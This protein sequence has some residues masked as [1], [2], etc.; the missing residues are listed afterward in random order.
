MLINS[1]L[2][3]LDEAHLKPT[4]VEIQL[5]YLEIAIP[6][7][8]KKVTKACRDMFNREFG[9]EQKY[10]RKFKKLSNPEEDKILFRL[11]FGALSILVIDW[12]IEDRIGS[13]RLDRCDPFTKAAIT[14]AFSGNYL[15]GEKLLKEVYGLF[16]TDRNSDMPK[17]FYNYIQNN[18]SD[19]TSYL[20]KNHP[21]LFVSDEHYFL[22]K[23]DVEF[24]I[25]NYYSF[26]ELEE[27]VDEVIESREQIETINRLHK[28]LIY[29]GVYGEKDLSYLDDVCQSISLFFGAQYRKSLQSA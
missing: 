6:N 8:S 27:L 19:L 28:K 12:L 4:N 10:S 20:T 17:R 13:N 7:I 2:D 5:N 3:K 22:L 11:G 18:E 29:L 9:M 1:G 26:K 24:F 15:R 23:E 25:A 14:Y 21:M 16:S